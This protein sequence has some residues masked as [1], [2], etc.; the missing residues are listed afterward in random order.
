M[1]NFPRNCQWMKL[2]IGNF[3]KIVFGN[4]VNKSLSMMW[5]QKKDIKHLLTHQKQNSATGGWLGG[6]PAPPP[7]KTAPPDLNIGT[8]PPKFF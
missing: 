6:A 8:P 1:G 7:K 3:K 2:E 5:G 4:R